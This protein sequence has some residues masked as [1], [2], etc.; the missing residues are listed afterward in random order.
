MSL[1]AFAASHNSEELLA[2]RRLI[3]QLAEQCG[4]ALSDKAAVRSFLDNDPALCPTLRADS[5]TDQ[6]LRTM[7]IL[8]FRLEASSS[9]DLG[10]EGLRR[11]WLQ[12]S[13]TLARHNVHELM[14]A[15]LSQ[16]L[17]GNPQV[18]SQ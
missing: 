11:L 17:S 18:T 4:L 12:H 9:E 10:F 2:L 3:A 14:P 8:L 15:K 13:E 7:L 16:G 6:E 5:N 1:S